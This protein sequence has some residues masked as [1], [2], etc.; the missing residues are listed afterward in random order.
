MQKFY[1]HLWQSGRCSSRRRRST[2]LVRANRR[3]LADRRAFTLVEMLIV[4]ML[5]SILASVSLISTDTSGSFSLEATTRMLVADLRLARNHAIKFN[6]KYTVNFD[7]DSQAYEI[8]H[9]GAGN[10]PVPQNHLAGSGADSDKYIKN[11]QI[12]SMNLPDQI[13]IRQI[14]LNTSETS[15]NDLTFGPM[16]GTGPSRNEDTILILSTEKNGTIFYIP[17][18]VSWITGQAWVEDIQTL[19]N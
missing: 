14:K 6:T 12:R 4:I 3:H 10:L 13:V 2:R 9:A 17:I 1:Q 8:L 18:T 5:I 16:G 11:L 19:T 15:V 7:L